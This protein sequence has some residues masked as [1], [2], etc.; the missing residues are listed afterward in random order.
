LTKAGESER[1]MEEGVGAL[2]GDRVEI[3]EEVQVRVRWMFGAT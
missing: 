1:W 3:P 2:V